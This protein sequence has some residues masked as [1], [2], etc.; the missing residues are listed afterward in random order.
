M[1]DTI[2][3]FIAIELPDTIIEHIALIQKKLKKSGLRARWVKPGNIHLTL[4]FLGDIDSGMVTPIADGLSKT[5]GTFDAITLFSKGIAICIATM[6]E[7]PRWRYGNAL[8]AA[9]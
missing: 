7:R 1:N 2:R 8:R 9:L 4:K 5:A 3:T 6:K